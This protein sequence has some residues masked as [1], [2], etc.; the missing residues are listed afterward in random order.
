LATS[1]TFGLPHLLIP[2]L[3]GPDR[4][5]TPFA[6]S[7]VSSVTYDET[8]TYA[9]LANYT[10]LRL[11]P[12]Y[13]T[14]LWETRDIPVPVTTVPFFALAALDWLSGGLDHAFIVCDFVL[15]PIAALVLYVLLLEVSSSRRVALIGSLATILISFGPRN[16]LGVPVLLLE[17]R[18]DAIL[19]P[20]EFSRILHPEVSFTLLAAALLL[21][22]RTIRRGSRKAA[23]LAGLNGGLLF[24]TYVYYFPVWLGACALSLLAWRWLSRPAWQAVLL[25]NVSTWVVSLPFWLSVAETS[26]TVN[27]GVRLARHFS[28]TGHVPPPEKLVY[29]SVYILIF[30]AAVAGFVKYQSA[31]TETRKNILIFHMSIFAAA[32]GAL[33]SE[34]VLGFN[35]EAM[36]HYPNRFFQPFLTLSMFGLL[37]GP[38]ASWVSTHARW[39][40]RAAT[41]VAY[42]MVTALLGVAVTRQTVVSFNVAD[43]H[44]LKPEYRL[45]FDWLNHYTQ[46]NDVVLTAERDIN[47]LLPV[48]THN[49]VFVPNGERTSAGDREIARRFLIAMRLLQLPETTVHDLLAQDAS[50]GDPPLG[51]TYTYFLFVSGNG[52]DELRMPEATLTPLLAEYRQL[53]LARELA[54]TRLNYIY[55]RGTQEPVAVPGLTFRWVYGDPYGT[56]W[57]VVRAV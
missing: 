52:S 10:A 7:G 28:E 12:P 40:R 44:E 48:F 16:F 24:Y 55:G 15:P 22:W 33:N 51:L 8:A 31:S 26:D 5:Y 39:A 34:V 18:A 1:I 19:Q 23:I 50:H 35:L 38:T 13:D 27:F 21:F 36:N 37:A 17:G 32:I 49:L 20:L 25:M 54:Q 43:R 11:T 57:E 14:D 53:D 47:D 30:V 41:L 46:L 3:L 2:Y 56:V 6:I 9:A 29:T 45:L 42:G 4:P